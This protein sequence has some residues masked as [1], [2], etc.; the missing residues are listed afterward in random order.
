MNRLFRIAVLVLVVLPF[1]CVGIPGCGPVADPQPQQG[2]F[3]AEEAQAA[4][5]VVEV[6]GDKAPPA[7]EG[8]PTSSDGI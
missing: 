5:N 4:D 3:T 6:P 7:P 8:E 2:D 1:L